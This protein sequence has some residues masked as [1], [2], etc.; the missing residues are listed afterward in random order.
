ML[1]AL[2]WV[3][4]MA[5]TL[6]YTTA[7]KLLAASLGAF[8]LMFALVWL[9]F[10]ARGRAACC[11]PSQ[12]AAERCAVLEDSVMTDVWLTPLPDQVPM[13]TITRWLSGVPTAELQPREE[14][15]RSDGSP[16]L[17]CGG[18]ERLT[19][20]IEFPTRERG[21]VQGRAIG[22]RGTVQSD[23][24]ARVLAE[25]RAEYT[26]WPALPGG[27]WITPIT[28]FTAKGSTLDSSPA[29]VSFTSDSKTRE[30][31]WH[32]KMQVT[33][34]AA[35]PRQPIQNSTKPSSIVNN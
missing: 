25:L 4:L 10:D 19:Q 15:R 34:D 21:T 18:I 26:I 16:A 7:A 35:M 22:G 33:T 14:P 3:T 31:Q 20:G 28:P 9:R 29:I 32:D 1:V 2:Q 30:K 12:R 11:A 13:T 23:A 5:H 17:R 24:S 8:A 6:H 27:H